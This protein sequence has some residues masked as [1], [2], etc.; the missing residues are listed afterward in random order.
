M[1]VFPT[2]VH[3]D[4]AEAVVDF[5]RGQ[6][7]QAVLLVNSCA[8]GVGTRESDVDIALLI[9]TQTDAV[10]SIELAWIE[11]Y[12]RTAV[13]RKLERLSS[14]VHSRNFFRLYLLHVESIPSLIT[15]TSTVERPRIEPASQAT[16]RIAGTMD[17]KLC[18]SRVAVP[19]PALERNRSGPEAR[20]RAQASRAARRKMR[21]CGRF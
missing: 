16:A 18:Q 11:C 1:Q 10:K 4:A 17:F 19:R 20:G 9:D 6:P 15:N 14:I 2:S 7:V 21:R 5:A 13:F 3:R 8:R 12:E